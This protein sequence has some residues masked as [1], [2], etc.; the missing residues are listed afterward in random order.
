MRASLSEGRREVIPSFKANC[1]AGGTTLESA[2]GKLLARQSFPLVNIKQ[3]Q[4][5]SQSKDWP[6]RSMTM[7]HMKL[8]KRVNG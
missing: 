4:L 2:M 1:S 8:V 3:V 5:D 6:H 7:A